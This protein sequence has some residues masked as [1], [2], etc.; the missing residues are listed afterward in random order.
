[1]EFCRIREQRFDDLIDSAWILEGENYAEAI[2]LYVQ[3]Q[4]LVYE[5]VA[6]VGLWDEIRP[7]IYSSR[8]NLPEEALNPLYMFVIRFEL[9]E[10]RS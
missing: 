5:D 4:R 3:A 1:M 8:I 10:V 9:V 7:F 2:E 6:A